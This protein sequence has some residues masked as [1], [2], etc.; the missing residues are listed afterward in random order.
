MDTAAEAKHH[1][2]NVIRRYPS[3]DPVGVEPSSL[4]SLIR[5]FGIAIGTAVR[6]AEP[7]TPRLVYREHPTGQLLI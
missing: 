4:R 6:C 3:C 7:D 2:A 5:D 1:H